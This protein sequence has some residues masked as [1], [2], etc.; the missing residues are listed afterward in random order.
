MKMQIQLTF[1]FGF[2]AVLSYV[3]FNFLVRGAYFYLMYDILMTGK[4]FEKSDWWKI[5]ILGVLTR[6]PNE[7][8]PAIFRLLIDRFNFYGAP[9]E[10]VS[11]VTEWVFIFL[12]I[13]IFKSVNAND[14]FEKI[15]KTNFRKFLPRFAFIAFPYIIARTVSTIIPDIIWVILGENMDTVG[16]FILLAMIINVLLLWLI[17]LAFSRNKTVKRGTYNLLNHPT[18]IRTNRI[19]II[20]FVVLSTI[21]FS[22]LFFSGFEIHGEA[23]FLLPAFLLTLFGGFMIYRA[24]FK[25]VRNEVRRHDEKQ[26]LRKQLAAAAEKYDSVQDDA[27]LME[28]SIDKLD[29]LLR[30]FWLLCRADNIEFG[31]MGSS[32]K[33]LI[34]AGVSEDKLTA[35]FLNILDNSRRACMKQSPDEERKIFVESRIANDNVIMMFHDSGAPMDE[36]VYAKIGEKYNTSEKASGGTGLGLYS[37]KETVEEYAGEVDFEPLMSE[38]YKH[39]MIQFNLDNVK[40]AAKFYKNKPLKKSK[41]SATIDM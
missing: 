36:Q 38:T 16:M 41:N 17:Y 28:L 26:E 22:Y 4:R 2:W 40:S 35:L 1:Q 39:I 9:M 6:I 25:S 29:K 31:I 20:T 37:I 11:Y 24:A 8:M 3:I 30:E 23:I 13:L 32:L 14:E 5:I 21:S 19:S 33:P 7:V 10:L 34:R 27:C 18:Y 15:F 12:I